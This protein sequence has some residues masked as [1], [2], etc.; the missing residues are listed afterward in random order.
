MNNIKQSAEKKINEIKSVIKKNKY[1]CSPIIEAQYH[2]SFEVNNNKSKL[3]V[4]V[5]FGKKGVKVVLQGNQDEK[6]YSEIND[7]IFEQGNLFPNSSIELDEPAAYIGTDESGKGDFFGPLVVAGVYVDEK[8]KR[9][10]INL[11][12]RDSKDLSEGQISY[13]SKRIREIIIDNYEIIVLTPE[14]YNKEYTSH[15]NLN[16]ML[17][18]IHEKVINNL[19][20]KIECSN[21]IID[22][23]SKLEI[24][25]PKGINVKYIHKAEKYSAVAAA[26]ILARD[27][28]NKWFTSKEKEGYNLLKG[29]SEDVEQSAK[30]FLKNHGVKELNK[31]VKMHFKTYKKVTSN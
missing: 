4:L 22:K 2:F 30:I 29:A 15:K 25:V 3:K 6:I 1:N 13:L 27:E 26:S 23:F 31:L 11:Q 24:D 9:S 5:Y 28:F 17:S 12:V 10:L 21:V 18:D 20:K 16:H 7:L 8:I 14:K 19:L